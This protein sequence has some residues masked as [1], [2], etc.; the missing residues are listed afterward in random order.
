[1][2][3][4]QTMIIDGLS[5]RYVGYVNT[6]YYHRGYAPYFT[7]EVALGIMADYLSTSYAIEY[8]VEMAYDADADCFVYVDANGDIDE[9][10]FGEDIQ[11]EDGVKHLYPFGEEWMWDIQGEVG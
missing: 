5:G 8:D 3:T 10:W 4:R 2:R 9:R 6:A 11:T 7:L 1:M